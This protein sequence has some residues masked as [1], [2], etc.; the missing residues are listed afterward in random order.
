MVVKKYFSGGKFAQRDDIVTRE[1]VDLEKSTSIALDP[2]RDIRGWQMFDSEN[3]LISHAPSTVVRHSSRFA[4]L[5]HASLVTCLGRLKLYSLMEKVGAANLVYQDTDSLVFTCRKDE[6]NPLE[7]ELTGFLGEL[8]DE[9][10][11]GMTIISIV[12]NGPKS[13]AYK[14]APKRK[15]GEMSDPD[16]AEVRE[17]VKCKGIFQ[18]EGTSELSYDGLV[19][20]VTDHLDPTAE[21]HTIRVPQSNI[22]RPDIGTLQSVKGTKIIRHVNNKACVIGTDPQTAY[23]VPYGY[24]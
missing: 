9:I 17:V 14:I 4:A 6:P 11:E 13:Y 8:S 5:H 21:P 18:T 2:S 1:F 24:K 20:I 3:V 16:P 7:A 15:S 22:I 12:C 23:R 19:K 10:E